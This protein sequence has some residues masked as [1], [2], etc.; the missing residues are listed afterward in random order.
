MEDKKIRVN[1]ETHRI[2]SDEAKKS[3]RTKKATVEEKFK[4]GKQK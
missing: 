2:I 3:N 4:K 1:E